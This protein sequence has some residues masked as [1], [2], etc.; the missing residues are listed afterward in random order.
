MKTNDGLL[1]RAIP[2]VTQ[3]PQT[4]EIGQEIARNSVQNLGVFV[5]ETRK[6]RAAARKQKVVNRATK[7][8]R[9]DWRIWKAVAIAILGRA[10]VHVDSS[11]M[12]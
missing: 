6:K 3:T 5:P 11:S 10:V 2:C 9:P 8:D 12:D 7:M 1:N 4:E